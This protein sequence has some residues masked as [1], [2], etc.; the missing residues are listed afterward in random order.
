MAHLP[1][2]NGEDF[3]SDGKDTGRVEESTGG[4]E[5]SMPAL[6]GERTRV[7]GEEHSYTL[8]GCDQHDK[9]GRAIL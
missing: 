5:R 1:G 7:E 6:G 8:R 9:K 4:R 3:V 2:K